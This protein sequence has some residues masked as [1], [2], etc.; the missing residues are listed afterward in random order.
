MNHFSPKVS[1][2]FLLFLFCK[3]GLCHS[4]DYYFSGPD[5]VQFQ[6]L[7]ELNRNRYSH[8][9]DCGVVIG[10]YCG[11]TFYNLGKLHPLGFNSAVHTHPTAR[12]TQLHLNELH[13]HNPSACAI[14]NFVLNNFINCPPPDSWGVAGSEVG[15]VARSCRPMEWPGE[16]RGQDLWAI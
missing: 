6:L 11:S 9:F 12:D 7:T 3:V 1:N 8:R 16:M 13:H 15:I 2:L 10:V 14:G 4:D 5:K